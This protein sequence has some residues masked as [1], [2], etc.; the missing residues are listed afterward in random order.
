MATLKTRDLVKRFGHVQVIHGLDL[1]ISDGEFVALV[2]PSGCG[3]STLLR[4]IAGLEDVSGGQMWIGEGRVEHLPP[5]KRDV[6]MVF[7]S[8][9]LFPHMTVRENIAY[10][11]KVRGEAGDKVE[12]SAEL[13][14][15]TPYLDRYPRELS[16]G[17]RQRVAMGRALQREPRLFL[18]DEPLSN[19]DAQLRVAMR[20][21]IKALHARL[22]NTV[23]YVTHDQVEAMTMADRIVVMRDGR[24]EQEGAPLAIYDR[25]NNVFVAGFIGSPAMSFLNGRIEAG[26]L[27]LGG[28]SIPVDTRE[29]AVIVGVRPEGFTMAGGDTGLE[30]EVQVI[31]PMGPETHVLANIVDRTLAARSGGETASDIRAVLRERVNLGTGDRQRLSV[32][33][34]ALHLFD[35]ESGMRLAD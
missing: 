20:A 6:A 34:A 3:K 19:L 27:T 25:P 1:D 26:R 10:G 12:E 35:P 32:D 15:L 8:Y 31:E 23:V 13:L 18:F 4:M 16:G 17:Q 24:I 21:E 2:G 33:P 30:V 28:L 14:N 7:Q 29:G 11:P 22:K 9:A 5:Q